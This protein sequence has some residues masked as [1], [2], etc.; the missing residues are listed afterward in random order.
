M[1]GGQRTLTQSSDSSNTAGH[2]GIT[3]HPSAPCFLNQLEV[4]TRCH[5]TP[6]LQP[7]GKEKIEM[8]S[9]AEGGA[10]GRCQAGPVPQ[11]LSKHERTL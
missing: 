10:T 1:L 7:S 3:L 8:A 2:S 4:Y 6:K 9:F 11:T 5:Q